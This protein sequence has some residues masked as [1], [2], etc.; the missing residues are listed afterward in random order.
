MRR[1][2]MVAAVLAIPWSAR[3]AQENG[4]PQRVYGSWRALAY[5]LPGAYRFIDRLDLTEEQQ[6]A[7][8]KVY[9]DW[10]T[11]R[12]ELMRRALETLPPL[13]AEERKDP[14][15]LKAYY[16]KRTDLYKAAQIPPPVAL[17]NLILSDEQVER[18]LE[19]NKVVEAWRKSLAE[20]ME[21]YDAKLDGLLGPAPEG[22]P[23]S[24]TYMYRMFDA[25]IPGGSLLV[26]LKLSDKQTAALEGLRKRYYT[27]YREK[28]AQLSLSLRGG[29]ISYAHMRA[30]RRSVGAKAQAEVK[31][32]HRKLL[33]KVLTEAQ[34]S[35][36][37]DAGKIVEERD[38]VIWDRYL[39]YV[40]E[41]SAILPALKSPGIP[42]K[43]ET[44]KGK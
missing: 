12:R 16:A 35:L 32:Q 5:Q 23:A 31:E 29:Q 34:Q 11:E 41:F 25:L 30:A 27:E 1:L 24:R 6:K 42:D 10:S 15:R 39:R 40:E 43:K 2:W 36:L 4:S 22:Q 13:T 9:K 26:R 28:L 38:K 7:L 17:V 37:A 3:A 21:T 8:D 19:A 20:C 18:I 33:R 44:G 14:E